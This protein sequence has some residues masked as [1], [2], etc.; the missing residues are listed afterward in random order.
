[1]GDEKMPYLVGLARALE[2][3]E[4]HFQDEAT[5]VCGLRDW[6]ERSIEATIPNVQ[7]NGLVRAALPKR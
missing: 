4:E 3:A 7:V 2:L 5:R 1:M 6:L